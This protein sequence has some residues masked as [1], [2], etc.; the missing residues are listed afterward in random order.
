[1]PR[2]RAPH[3]CLTCPELVPASGGAQCTR[4]KPRSGTRGIYD[5]RSWKRNAREFLAAHP[6][7]IDCGYP[8][9]HADH[10]PRSRAEL[11]AVGVE[12]PDAWQHLQPRCHSCHSRRTVLEEGGLGRR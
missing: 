7:C 3:R 5:Q 2:P 8:S 9:A 6:M 12:N 11:V 10:A 4:C 1:M